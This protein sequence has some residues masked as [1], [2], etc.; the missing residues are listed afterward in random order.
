MWM[1]I[2]K[3][4]EFQLYNIKKERYGIP[5]PAIKLPQFADGG[6]S[7]QPSIF[8]EAGWEVAIPINN[9]QRS[10]DLLEKTNRIMGHT[11]GEGNEINVTWAPQITVQ[12]GGVNVKQEVSQLLKQA[13]TSS[14]ADSLP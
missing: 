13:Q 7:N 14:S 2:I 8:G 6:F 4:Q 5:E 1:W 12:G 10:H 3:R 11:S 9:K